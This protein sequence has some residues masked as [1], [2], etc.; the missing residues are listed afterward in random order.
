MTDRSA[1]EPQEPRPP[2]SGRRSEHCQQENRRS[3]AR[4]WENMG[5]RWMAAVAA[6]LSGW[7]AARPRPVA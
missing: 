6:R 3:T 5:R 2:E 4:G 7:V 1:E